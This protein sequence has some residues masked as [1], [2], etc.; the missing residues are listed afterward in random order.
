MF[1]VYHKIGC[2]AELLPPSFVVARVLCL[3]KVVQKAFVCKQLPPPCFKWFGVVNNIRNGANF[4]A[5]TTKLKVS[6]LK[7]LLFVYR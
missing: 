6:I 7:D 4:V 1:K 2:Q 3:F 5:L